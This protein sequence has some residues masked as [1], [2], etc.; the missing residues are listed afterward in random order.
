MNNLKPISVSKLLEPLI[1][2]YFILCAISVFIFSSIDVTHSSGGIHNWCDNVN[3]VDTDS[4]RDFS[5]FV[6]AL[7]ILPL[8][9]S[10][11]VAIKNKKYVRSG[12]IILLIIYWWWEFFGRFLQC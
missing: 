6:N 7:L 10:L 3:G 11:P 5:A 12:L 1:Y 8:L 2:F 9:I 4:T